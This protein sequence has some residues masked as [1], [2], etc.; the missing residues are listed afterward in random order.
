MK[1][2]DILYSPWTGLLLILLPWLLL[3]GL[4]W[5]SAERRAEEGAG[6]AV[7]RETRA[8]LAYCAAVK[9]LGRKQAYRERCL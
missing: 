1:V 7:E 6:K 2:R 5:T 9:A 4:W 3:A 8:H